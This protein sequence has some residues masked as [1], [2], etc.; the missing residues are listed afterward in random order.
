MRQCSLVWQF[1]FRRQRIA[2]VALICLYYITA[3]THTQV[4][5]YLYG[6]STQIHL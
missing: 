3:D 4:L 6:E 5:M 2:A 1:D